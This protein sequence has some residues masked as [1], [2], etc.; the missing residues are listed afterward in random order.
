MTTKNTFLRAAAAIAL[1]LSGGLTEA[2][3]ALITLSAAG[4][5]PAAITA[6]RDS[7]RESIGGGSVAGANGSFGGLRREIN[8][9]GVPDGFATPNALPANFFN[10]N[11]P[12]GAVFSTSGSA[13]V[14]SANASSGTAVLFANLNASYA[15][16]FQ[17]FTAQRLFGVLDEPSMDIDFFVPG[18]T[19]PA[20][21]TA[22]GAVFVDNVGQAFPNCASIQAFNGAAS[23][24]FFCAPVAPAGGLSF[25]GLRATG[26]EVITRI[27]LNLGNGLLGTQQS[28]TN[29]VVVMDD[30][31][32]SEPLPL[33][34]PEPT[35][36]ALSLLGAV[37]LAHRARRR[38]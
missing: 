9:D 13:F 28:S 32:Y 8:W 16:Q 22:F 35:T 36:L 20:A 27:R 14:V 15:G 1:L 2:H 37:A 29:E 18:T 23:L 38:R 31:I 6:A 5:T 4:S 19:T 30:F 12:R 3:A 24:G 17:A 21:V 25:L 33:P 7:F 11:S 10:V 26:G 34:V